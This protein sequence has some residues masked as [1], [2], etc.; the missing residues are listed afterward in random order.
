MPITQ[1]TLR[2][3]RL[4]LPRSSCGGMLARQ[5]H[6]TARA[7]NSTAPTHHATDLP[8][9]NV[10]HEF[11]P[12]TLHYYSCHGPTMAMHATSS[13]PSSESDVDKEDNR[14]GQDVV[15]VQEDGL[16]YPGPEGNDPVWN[17][18]MMMPHAT[19][20]LEITENYYDGYEEQKAAGHN[21][22][23]PYFF[24]VPKGGYVSILLLQASWLIS[25]LYPRITDTQR[26]SSCPPTRGDV[27]S[28][29]PRRNIALR[30]ETL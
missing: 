4:L 13:E 18:A 3:L 5:L 10:Y 7:R 1:A 22:P 21:V 12:C 14:L 17:G 26:S 6:V 8:A 30:Y 20:L 29:A 9:K 15:R 27:P 24:T 2:Q 28:Y 11:F 19:F 25:T 16:V 23:E